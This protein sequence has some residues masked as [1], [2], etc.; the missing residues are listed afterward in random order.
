MVEQQQK[1]KQLA[2]KEIV[3]KFKDALPERDTKTQ[4]S[5]FTESTGFTAKVRQKTVKRRFKKKEGGDRKENAMDNVLL[6]S[7]EQLS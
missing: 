6:Q 2:Q 3:K 5:H 4:L 7:F 1:E